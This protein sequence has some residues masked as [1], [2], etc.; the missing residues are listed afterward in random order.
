MN[1]KTKASRRAVLTVGLRALGTAAAMTA[2]ANSALAGPPHWDKASCYIHVHDGCYNNQ[3]S[4]C[5]DAEYQGFL[6]DCNKT[7]PQVVRPT[8]KRLK[9]FK[10]Q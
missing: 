6:A 3:T 5:S 2:F 1:T 7:Y 8:N 9:K 10:I 4:P